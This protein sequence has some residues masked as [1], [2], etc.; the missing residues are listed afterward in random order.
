[1]SDNF[2]ARNV[3]ST[4]SITLT[5]TAGNLKIN[6]DARVNGCVIASNSQ[7]NELNVVNATSGGT[8]I[9]CTVQIKDTTNILGNI[10]NNKSEM[11]THTLTLQ[12]DGED[13]NHA[14]GENQEG[15]VMELKTGFTKNDLNDMLVRIIA[16]WHDIMEEVGHDEQK[17]CPIKNIFLK[18]TV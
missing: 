10:A 11:I 2:K 1:M 14:A 17:N 5:P 15:N 18:L 6:Y 3:N 9:N 16:Q 13:K 4:Y 7:T 12:T 8:P